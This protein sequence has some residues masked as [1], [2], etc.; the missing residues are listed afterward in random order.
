MRPP[1]TTR[2]A[3]AYRRKYP[4]SEAQVVEAFQRVPETRIPQDCDSGFCRL[5]RVSD[6]APEAG[7]GSESEARPSHHHRGHRDHREGRVT[8]SRPGTPVAGVQ[9]SSVSSAPSVV[10]CRTV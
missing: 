8:R 1:T 10:F 9:S 4:S 2:Q 5:L 3:K 6:E 7:E